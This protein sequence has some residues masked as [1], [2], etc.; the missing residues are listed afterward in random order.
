M[1]PKEDL[2]DL[3]NVF[4]PI[5]VED[6]LNIQPA[7]NDHWFQKLDI[8]DKKFPDIDS[9]AIVIIGIVSEESDFENNYIRDF[10]YSYSGSALAENVADLGNFLYD[11]TDEKIDEKLGYI[12][13]EIIDRGVVPI[14]LGLSQKHTI[15][16]FLAFEYLKKLANLVVIDSKIDFFLNEKEEKKH[17]YLHKI[18]M[19]DP[20][21]LFNLSLMGFQTYLTEPSTLEILEQ[22]HFDL[23]RLGVLRDDIKAME[24]VIR[25]ADIMSFDLSAI[26][27]SDSPGVNNPSPN[28]LFAHEACQLTHYAGKSDNIRTLGFYE[29]NSSADLNHQTARLIAQMIWY[30]VE[31]YVNHI[32][33]KQIGDQSFK[34][35]IVTNT[36]NHNIVFYKSKKTDRWWMEVPT[37]KNEKLYLDKQ[38]I[39]CSYK[40]YDEATKGMVPERWWKA[41]QKLS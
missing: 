28:G 41:L 19:R 23:Y 40:D 11:S 37:L 30:F 12:L 18:L 26:R 32:S 8:F 1:S 38:I 5:H 17:S 27:Q 10:L 4:I 29:F 35:Y 6:E 9:K 39:P 31:G 7:T 25:S 34:K 2:I 3:S 16:Q 20:S 36:E 15:S 24:A 33:E 14:L 21:Y 22:H 13:C